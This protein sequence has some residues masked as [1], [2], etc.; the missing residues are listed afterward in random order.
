MYLSTDDRCIY[1]KPDEIDSKLI[2]MKAGSLSS[3]RTRVLKNWNLKLES[4][5]QIYKHSS[6][7]TVNRQKEYTHTHTLF[8]S[9][10]G[11]D[12]LMTGNADLITFPNSTQGGLS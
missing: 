10:P 1:V 8:Y 2:V 3:K 6:T 12:R 7:Q 9:V 11:L 5:I 4:K